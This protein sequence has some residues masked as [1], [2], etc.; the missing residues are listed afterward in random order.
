MYLTGALFGALTGVLVVFLK[1][2]APVSKT[3][4]ILDRYYFIIEEKI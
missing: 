3:E 4:K 2:G 1:K